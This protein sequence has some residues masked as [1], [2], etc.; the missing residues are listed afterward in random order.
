MVVTYE[1][2]SFRINVQQKSTLQAHLYIWLLLT[3]LKK[4][5]TT[6]NVSAK[7]GLV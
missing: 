4:C 1:A 3:A 7:Y 6:Q 2:A 5:I